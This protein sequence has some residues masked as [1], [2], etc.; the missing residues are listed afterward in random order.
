M[1]LAPARIGSLR[2]GARRNS[3]CR[4]RCLP[5]QVGEGARVVQRPEQRVWGLRFAVRL[6]WLTPHHVSDEIRS[7]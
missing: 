7:A 2:Y 6:E 1:D 5:A 3:L 4:P